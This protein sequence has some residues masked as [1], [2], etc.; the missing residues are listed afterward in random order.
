[1]VRWRRREIARVEA[2]AQYADGPA[3]VQAIAD[4]VSTAARRRVEVCDYET[5]R[6]SDGRT[7]VFVACR[8]QEEGQSAAASPA[9]RY[10]VGL[11]ENPAIACA[12]ALISAVNRLEWRGEGEDEAAAA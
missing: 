8:V 5:T 3:W 1:V 10:G 7:A 12:D 9:V 11:H 4:A 6:A 2:A